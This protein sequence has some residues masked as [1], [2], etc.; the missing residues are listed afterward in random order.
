MHLSKLVLNLFMNSILRGDIDLWELKKQAAVK[1]VR[2]R[3][4][5]CLI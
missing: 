2:A 1:M 5:V 3:R 4:K